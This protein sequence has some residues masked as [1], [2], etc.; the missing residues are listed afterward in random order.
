MAARLL[1]SLALLLW[2]L[3]AAAAVPTPGDEPGLSAARSQC[4][5]LLQGVA[6]AG[7]TDFELAAHCRAR[8]PPDVCHRTHAALGPQPWPAARM[9]STCGL[10]EAE[11]R[12]YAETLSPDRRLQEFDDLKKLLDQV[13]A[14][15]A[16]FGLL[17]NGTVGTAPKDLNLVL[18]KKIGLTRDFEHTVLL[19]WNLWVKGALALGEIEQTIEGEL[20]G[21]QETPSWPM[22]VAE[23]LTMGDKEVGQVVHY[24]RPDFLGDWEVK[25]GNAAIQTSGPWGLLAAGLLAVGAVAAF[26]GAVLRTGRR[27]AWTAAAT[28]QSRPLEDPASGYE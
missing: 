13:L 25:L 14:A 21:R 10:W 12:A 22:P 6:A 16:G 4:H 9:Q 23:K 8:L 5:K 18:E 26:A 27:G 3:P 7:R 19:K 24:K 28:A 2:A 1:L 15:K 17:A 11:R 20:S